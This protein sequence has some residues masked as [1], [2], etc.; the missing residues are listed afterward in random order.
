MTPNASS[1]ID[2][3][4]LSSP[5]PR[6]APR[7]TL[8]SFV[9]RLAASKGV[10]TSDFYLDMGV[11]LR[12]MAILDEEAVA[13]VARWAGLNAIEMDELLSRTGVPSGNI[14]MTFRG[15]IIGSRALRNPEMR[16]CRKCLAKDAQRNPDFPLKEMVMRGDWLFRDVT[17][18][19]EHRTP[20][21]VLWTEHTRAMRFDIGSR[22]SEIAPNHQ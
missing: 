14:R 2:F 13:A 4:W 8:H 21:E 7:E 22:L 17:I 3:P 10:S 1:Y 5:P 11:S 19:I 20:L 6:P 16:G 9:S 18:C 12:S 15:Q